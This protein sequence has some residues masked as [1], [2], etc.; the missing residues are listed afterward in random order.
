M[1]IKLLKTIVIIFLFFFQNSLYSKN[2]DSNYLSSK[3]LAE[4]LSAIT[5]YDNGENTKS[6]EFFDKS[7][8]LIDEHNPYLKKY[9]F[10]LITEGKINKAIKVLKSNLNK[11]NSNFFESYLLLTIDSI[12]N[13]D[14]KKSNIYLEKL[15]NFTSDNKFNLLIF[16]SLKKYNYLFQNKKILNEKSSFNNLLYISKAFENCYIGKQNESI[17]AFQNLINNSD[18]DYTRYIFF[19]INYLSQEK[20]F[21]KA[22]EVAFEI[23]DLNSSLLTFQTK[24]LVNKGEF[25]KINKIFSCQ[26]ELDVLSEFFFLVSNLYSGQQNFNKSNF[27]LN[28]SYFLN[29]KF[30]FNLSLMVENY[31]LDSEYSKSKKVLNN[32]DIN[33]GIYYWYKIK[34]NTDIMS[35]EKNLNS[36]FIYLNSNFSNIKKP[37]T[38]IIFDMANLAKNFKKYEIA[39]N[40]YNKVLKDIDPKSQIYA[41]VLYRRGASYERI[42]EFEKSDIDLIESLKIDPDNAYVLNYLA[43]SWLER[44]Y[45]IS[46]AIKMLERA[47]EIKSNDPF[48]LDSVGWAYYLTNDF[49]KAEEFL[50]SAI[51]LMPEDPVV[52]D[53][54]AD[55]L[56][57]LNRKIEANYYW[58][59]VLKFKDTE[60]KMKKDINNKILKGPNNT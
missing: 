29:P 22:K 15:S 7:K 60:E 38:K 20:K 1:L 55:I 21:K 17:S 25:K 11:E 32:Y 40:Y 6:L 47:Y 41:D 42:K 14:F 43:Y 23:E 51:Q 56:W 59:S 26:E 5:S 52:N 39:I 58:Q 35:K 31:Y 12:K 49:K 37:S 57:R 19:Y 46:E 4:Y 45:K 3:N 30:K 27:Y 34:K 9:I 36:S 13:K 28:I 44:N 8:L 24:T 16:E 54:Y 48:I 18:I 2:K 33:D 50:R 53:H 10:S